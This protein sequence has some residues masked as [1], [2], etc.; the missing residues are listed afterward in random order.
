MGGCFI[1]SFQLLV[2]SIGFIN[3][4]FMVKKSCKSGGNVGASS[5]I[6]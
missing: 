3:T 5:N 2:F 4:I 6:A 1:I